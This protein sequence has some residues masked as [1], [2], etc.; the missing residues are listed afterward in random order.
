M[1]GFGVFEGGKTSWTLG[2]NRSVY[3]E[4]FAL[5]GYTHFDDDFYDMDQVWLGLALG[6]PLFVG[7]KY[8]YTSLEDYNG[9]G[10]SAFAGILIPAGEHF[11]L[12]AMSGFDA[13]N[14][15]DFPL[16]SGYWWASFVLQL[17]IEK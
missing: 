6:D 1:G 7:A 12:G 16:D 9:H 8:I 14:L 13:T 17:N 5:G 2:Y 15:D 4:L 11:A 3:H 10:I